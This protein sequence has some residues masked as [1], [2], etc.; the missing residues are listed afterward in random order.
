MQRGEQSSRR[1]LPTRGLSQ[2]S[3]LLAS[4]VAA[5]GGA[6][7]KQPPKNGAIVSLTLKAPLSNSD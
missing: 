7:H 2:D 6:G 1:R 3:D 4:G 5:T